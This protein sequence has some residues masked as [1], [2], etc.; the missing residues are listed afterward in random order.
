MNSTLKALIGAVLCIAL[1]SLAS[2]KKDSSEQAA[3]VSN[4]EASIM[5]QENAEAEAEYDDAA[6]IGLSAGADL[7]V[8]VKAAR[9]AGSNATGVNLGTRLDL[10][11]DLYFKLGPCA[12]ITVTPND[13]TFPKTV[14]IDYGSGCICRDGKFRKGV[15]TLHFSAPVRRPGAVLTITFQGYYV[16]RKHIEGIKIITNLSADGA[17]KYSV[18]V[19]DG[20]ITWP[21][22]RGFTYAGIKTVTQVSGMA[23]LTVRDDVYSIEGRAETKYANGVTV[24]KITKTP[25]IKPVACSWIVQGVLGIKIN[26]AAFLVDFGNGGCNNKAILTNVNLQTEIEITLP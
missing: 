14:T 20:K 10:F 12:R 22:G 17:V 24:V 5:S 19:K 11:A 13:T 18:Q 2:C 4:E 21:N 1:F 26:N 15:I 7:E 3:A 8:V 23:T 9:E 16:N 25:L 6:E